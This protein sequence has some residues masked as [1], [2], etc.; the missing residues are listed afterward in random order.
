MMIVGLI[1]LN[2][3]AL[4]MS[5]GIIK[6]KNTKMNLVFAV[7][8]VLAGLSLFFVKADSYKQGQIDAI[9]GKIVYELTIQENGSTDWEK[10]SE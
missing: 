7:A 2:M 10:T 8:W 3:A 4:V 5:Y 6:N 1:C 9:N